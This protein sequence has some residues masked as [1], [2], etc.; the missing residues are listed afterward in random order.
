MSAFSHYGSGVHKSGSLLYFLLRKQHNID[1]GISGETDFTDYDSNYYEDSI[2]INDNN[3]NTTF[4]T[5]QKQNDENNFLKLSDFTDTDFC[6]AMKYNIHQNNLN[7]PNLNIFPTT[8][9]S[10]QIL[11]TSSDVS[12]GD[13]FTFDIL[14]TTTDTIYF[15]T[16][17]SIPT[18]T[19][20]PNFSQVT[21]TDYITTL[22]Y[23]NNAM[24]TSLYTFYL[25][26]GGEI[27]HYTAVGVQLQ[28]T[29]SDPF[30]EQLGGGF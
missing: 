22:T 27:T 16:Y 14:K 30:G 18:N 9:V 7:V 17:N 6:F 15:N 20:S 1:F 8:D 10:Y 21:I 2:G 12:Y 25:G 5:L 11:V 3:N 24:N 28:G 13:T 23:T 26:D 29:S 19:L 4:L